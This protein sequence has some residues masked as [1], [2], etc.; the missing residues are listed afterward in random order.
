MRERGAFDRGMGRDG[1]LER[2][3]SGVFLE[4]NMTTPLSNDD[5]A[6]PFEGVDKLVPGRFGTLPLLIWR[7]P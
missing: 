4:S 3:R 5:P 2:F 1:E 7:L 6:I